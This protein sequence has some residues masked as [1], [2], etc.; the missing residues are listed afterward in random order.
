MVSVCLCACALKGEDKCHVS[1]CSKSDTVSVWTVAAAVGQ[2]FSFSH[3][4]PICLSST[5]LVLFLSH[6]Y[7]HS[8]CF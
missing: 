3:L 6:F 5:L 2:A 4:N 7:I 1:A 8:V